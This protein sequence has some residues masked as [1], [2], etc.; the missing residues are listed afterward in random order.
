[1]ACAPRILLLTRD[2]VMTAIGLPP[3]RAPRLVSL[4]GLAEPAGKDVRQASR[5][6]SAG[7]DPRDVAVRSYQRGLDVLES[8]S[9]TRTCSD[10]VDPVRPRTGGD[11][12]AVVARQVEDDAAPGVQQL[13]GVRL[14]GWPEVARELDVWQA[15]AE[16][17][18]LALAD[19]VA[20]V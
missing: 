12:Q 10:D 6:G 4:V 16:Q 17:R 19:V 18:V 15:P 5:L 13:E 2:P 7:A 9:R 20:D 14:A 3:K 11:A 8:A 1:M